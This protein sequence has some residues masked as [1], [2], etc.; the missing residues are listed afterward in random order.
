MCNVCQILEQT[1]AAVDNAKTVGAESPSGQK[2]V[3]KMERRL[4]TYFRRIKSTFKTSGALDRTLRLYGLLLP[5]VI[6]G[7]ERQPRILSAPPFYALAEPMKPDCKYYLAESSRITEATVE[8]EFILAFSNW[9]E[10]ADPL[11]AF[12]FTDSILDGNS[13]GFEGSMAEWIDAFGIDVPEGLDVKGLLPD[14]VIQK[15]RDTAAKNVQHVD[16]ETIKR[17]ANTIGNALERNL[18]TKELAAAISETFDSFTDARAKLIAQTEMNIAINDGKLAA[19]VAVG[20]DEKEWIETFAGK[21]PREEHIDNMGDGRIPIGRPFSGDGSMD[22]GGGNNNP[23]NCH[24]TVVYF[25]ATEESVSRLLGL[26]A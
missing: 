23:F 19:N 24:C 15:A 26:A 18:T 2:L 20:A 8:A 21:E 6:E 16:E 13:N 14:S 11:L 7:T 12:V 22:A 3:R 1:A 9:L 5:P 17:L 10:T 25:G 4:E